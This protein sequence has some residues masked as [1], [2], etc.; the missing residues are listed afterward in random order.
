MRRHRSV[1]LTFFLLIFAAA[2]CAGS[3]APR[4]ET[5]TLAGPVRVQSADLAVTLVR[6]AAQGD[7]ETLVEDP[8]WHEYGIEIENISTNTLT[9]RNVKLLD[10]DGVYADSASAYEQIIAPPDAGAELAGDV[11]EQAAGM[12]AGKIFPFGGQ[13]FGVLSGAV[14]TTSA[15][16]RANAKRAFGLRVLR[17]V[18]LAPAGKAE[19]S[20]FLPTI[21][22]AKALVVDYA[23]D[24]GTKRVEIALPT[25]EP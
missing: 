17:N 4:A 13:I 2:G 19:R 14:S 8:G 9:V 12:A 22:K 3:K 11:A 15:G 18:E 7:P 10:Q 16:A 20:A 6:I 24:G 5:L 1:L 21:A 25:R 23:Q